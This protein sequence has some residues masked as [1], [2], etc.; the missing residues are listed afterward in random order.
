MSAAATGIERAPLVPTDRTAKKWLSVETPFRTVSPG[1]RREVVDGPAGLGRFAPEDLEPGA[2]RV[3]RRGPGDLRVG[4]HAAGHRHVGGGRRRLREL[5]QDLGVDPGDVSQEGEIQVLGPVAVLAP[6]F[7]ARRLVLVVVVLQRLR[8]TDGRQA[9]FHE[10]AMVAAAPEAIEAE[11]E[12]HGVPAGDLLDGAGEVA[13]GRIDPVGPAPRE[14]ADAVGRAGGEIRADDVVVEDA[15]DRVALLLE[16]FEQAL[17]ADQALLFSRDGRKEQCRAV[18]AR[19]QQSRARDRDGHTRRVVVGA[20]RVAFRVHHG[21]R[22]RVEVAGHDEHG[23]GERGVAS[24]QKGQ[25]VFESR[26]LVVRAGRRRFEAVDEHL[27]A[28]AGVLRDGRETRG[29]AVPA[30][31][32]AAFR[33]LPGGERMA[34]AAGHEL[35]D[36]FAKGSF[37]HGRP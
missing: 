5:P 3:L 9:L 26:G 10:G 22:H 13:R 17:A 33:I 28:P 1:R 29:D 6:V 37:V 16:V 27:E 34:G 30:A 2:L 21:G 25:D 24:G 18:G 31:S 36:R 11:H 23:S 32:D 15:A 14:D 12:A 7:H 19:G 4:R 8:E 20:R 35:L